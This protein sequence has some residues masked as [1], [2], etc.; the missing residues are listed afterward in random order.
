MGVRSL[1]SQL[2][3]EVADVVRRRRFLAAE[4]LSIPRAVSGVGG[5]GNGAAGAVRE[6]DGTAE[7]NRKL[8]DRMP[9][10]P[11][12]ATRRP[13][14]N[15][16]WKPPGGVAARFRLSK[17]GDSRDGADRNHTASEDVPEPM[18]RPRDSAGNGTASPAE[19]D[20]ITIE[21]KSS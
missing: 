21:L 11:E 4:P 5:N 9:P 1:T 15:T 13:A 8:P 14:Q 12:L 20:A 7:A 6:A 10:L 18:V 19:S 16:R 3:A 17:Q 2:A